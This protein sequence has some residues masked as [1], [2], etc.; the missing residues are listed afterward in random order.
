MRASRRK[1]QSAPEIGNGVA[2]L[3]DSPELQRPVVYVNPDIVWER[4]DVGF[5]N[6]RWVELEPI[7]RQCPYPVRPLGEFIPETVERDG[8]E[9]RNH[10][11]VKQVDA[12]THRREPLSSIR[13]AA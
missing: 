4:G 12:N 6:P 5:W 11:T 3:E 13:T 9:A 10:A 8:S 2:E 7:L 1:R